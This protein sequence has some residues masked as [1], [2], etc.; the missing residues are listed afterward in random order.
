MRSGTDRFS[1]LNRQNLC[2]LAKIFALVKLLDLLPD[3]LD[4][5]LL[6]LPGECHL[7][8]AS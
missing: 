1:K 8:L 7:A 6:P 3:V 4:L 5:A 2:N